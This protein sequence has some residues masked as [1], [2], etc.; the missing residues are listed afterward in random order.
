MSLR[1]LLPAWL[2]P[3]AILVGAASPAAAATRRVPADHPT[4]QA[5]INAASSGD[6]I[7]VSAG[8][9]T[10]NIDFRGKAVTLESADGPAATIIDG[11]NARC[12]VQFATG[13]T[14]ATV[15]SGFTIQN[16]LDSRS[17]NSDGAGIVVSNA[18]PTITGNIIANNQGCSGVGIG[19][20][21]GS[22]LIQG[23][24]ITQNRH[25]TCSGGTGGGGIGIRGASSAQ[26]IGNTI[27]SNN[28]GNGGGGGI[29]LFAAG[30]PIIRG[31]LISGNVADT[32]GGAISMVNNS[33]A[34][35]T[36]NVIIQN[37][38]PHGGGISAL[39]PS[40]SAGPRIINNTFAGNIGSQ[41]FLEGFM[42]Q[43]QIWNN[44]VFGASAQAA[45]V[46]DTTFGN[47]IPVL[48]FNDTFNTSGP[49]Y[50]GSCANTTGADGNISVDPLFVSSTSDFQLGPSSPAI[51]AGS[52]AAPGLPDL[53][54]AGNPRVLDGT[55]DDIATV[56]MGAYERSRLLLSLT[57]SSLTFPGQ[58]VG[59]AGSPQQVTLTNVGDAVIT[60]A[61]VSVT[62]D[63][64]QTSTCGASVA[65]GA[66]CGFEITFTPTETGSRTGLFTIT[67]NATGSPHAVA[68]TGTGLAR[69]IALSPASLTFP[70]QLVGA[71]GPALPVTLTNTGDVPVAISEV[72][73]T[74]DFSQT[75]PCGS[76]V[77]PGASCTFQIAF[78]ATGA[79]S[80]MGTLTISDDATGGP[81][82]V[83][84]IG[85]GQDFSI[86]A[87][88][89]ATTSATVDAG[90]TAAYHLR[91][92]ADGGFAATVQLT[93][94]GAPE[95][96]ECAIVPAEVTP[97][98]GTAPF[99]VLVGTSGPGGGAAGAHVAI[100][101]VARGALLAVLALIIAWWLV[102]RDAVT[103]RRRRAVLVRGLTFALLCGLAVSGCHD[104]APRTPPGTVALTIQGAAAGTTRALTLS[105]TV[106]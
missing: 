69:S 44:V 12:V 45:I 7:V 106:R 23:N 104:H 64:S 89:G 75:N 100:P 18:S 97:D 105:L 16:G 73:V 79:G 102:G 52:N 99:T 103:Q 85:T 35:I 49:A 62:G 9:Y 3:L 11:G 91:V 82:T 33:N 83:A 37:L 22:P 63:F 74:G 1:S 10:E 70:G 56:D 41:I 54:F 30:N 46:C 59:A 86:E 68:L 58:P 55:G 95:G 53:D 38:A 26:I 25:T 87:A 29:S 98:G 21:S 31:N 42:E 28:A 77:A 48:R 65:P 96:A 92:A 27:T 39:V 4:I 36:N 101:P 24:I 84:L 13:E 72:A 88:P 51:D 80:R 8:T 66:S 6:I 90:D 19:V 2:V 78:M 47:R 57:P 40:G 67:D 81:H 17:C 5:A 15:I 93:C 32:E 20:A 71:R 43:T 94:S 14:S 60:I 61:E 76:S 50:A 34:V